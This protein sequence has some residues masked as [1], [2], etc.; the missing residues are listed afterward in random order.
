MLRRPVSSTVLSPAWLHC[1]A[2]RGIEKLIQLKE[3]KVTVFYGLAMKPFISS[4]KTMKSVCGA[5]DHIKLHYDIKTHKAIISLSGVSLFRNKQP[6]SPSNPPTHNRQAGIL[7]AS[8]GSSLKNVGAF[9]LK[10]Q[11]QLIRTVLK[12]HLINSHGESEPMRKKRLF[13]NTFTAKSIEGRSV[14]GYVLCG[15]L[16]IIFG[17][18]H[19][20][21][22][23]VCTWDKTEFVCVRL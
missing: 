2:G 4:N 23:K 13:G 15:T 12:S 5:T 17:Q 11:S 3:V 10:K 9:N 18:S 22:W 8:R 20:P 7:K 16:Y 1:S 19:G 6:P 21:A 14:S